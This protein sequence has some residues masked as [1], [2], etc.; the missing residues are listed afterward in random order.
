MEDKFL[1]LAAELARLEKRKREVLRELK[2]NAVGNQE[3][4]LVFEIL[5]ERSADK[6][7]FGDTGRLYRESTPRLYGPRLFRE[8]APRR[9]VLAEIRDLLASKPRREFPATEI[10]NHLGIEPSSEK[11]FYSALAKLH[12]L[13]QIQRVGRARYKSGRVQPRTR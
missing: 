13:G 6:F 2:A 12:H 9:N 1:V 11:S 8:S 5:D 4:Q 3:R 10:K 7:D